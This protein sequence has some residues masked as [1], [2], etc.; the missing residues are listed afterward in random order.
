M[1]LLSSVVG[2]WHASIF[3]PG[4]CAETTQLASCL[5]RAPNP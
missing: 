4:A 2:F 3:V 5:L 1:R